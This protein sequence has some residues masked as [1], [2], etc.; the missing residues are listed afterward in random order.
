MEKL[1]LTPSESFLL[2]DIE[3]KDGKTLMKYGLIN[4]LFKRVLVANVRVVNEGTLF[5]RI[6]N[7]TYI[8]KGEN[9]NDLNLKAHER[10]FHAV[11]FEKDELELV[12]LIKKIFEQY[13]YDDFYDL[14]INMQTQS[15]ILSVTEE[16]KFFN[17]FSKKKKKLTQKGLEIKIKIKELLNQGNN[18]L[19]KWL[20]EDPGRAKAYMVACGANLLLLDENN[21]GLLKKYDK[22]LE[23]VDRLKHEDSGFLF[24]GD[25]TGAGLNGEANGDLDSLS[26]DFNYISTFDSFDGLDSGFESAAGGDGSACGGYSGCGGC[27]GG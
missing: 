27:G 22:D 1:N 4:L 14:L 24:W 13:N 6:V 26:R 2:L 18:N 19:S 11:M 10:V 7:K 8:S 17:I 20:V 9:F 3:K 25:F 5:K 12:E 23:E 16:R 15:G 21:I